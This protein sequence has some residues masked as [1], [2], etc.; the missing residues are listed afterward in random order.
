MAPVMSPGMSWRGHYG[1]VMTVTGTPRAAGASSLPT[2]AQHEIRYGDQVAVV[3]EVGATLRRYDVGD[4]LVVEGFPAD[5]SP[6]GGRGQILAPWP[7]RVADGRYSFDGA[8]LQLPLT[9]VANHNAIHGLVRWVGWAVADAAAD[10][11]SLT[12][13]VWPTPGYPFLLVLTAAYRI[14][15]DGLQVELRARNAGPARA[16]YGAGQHPYLA[17]EGS[18]DTAVLTVPGRTR[19]LTDDRGNPTGT[20]PVAG[21]AHDFTDPR[22]IGD[23]VL[24]TA[25]TDLDRDP[26]GRVR[27]RVA[28]P[29][30]TGV[31]LWAGETVSWLQAFTGD[32]L[33]PERRRRGLAVEPM[34]CPPGALASGRDLT[35]L[36]PGEEHVLTWGLQA[37]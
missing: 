6:D 23:L 17:V 1:R 28:L 19:L 14:D 30:G 29:G 24:D 15:A 36:E 33:A 4:R 10:A 2:G 26:D 22:A 34:S 5:A 13:T 3:T 21:S 37:W 32:T 12:T 9:E 31:D 7:N 25:Y 18:V 27:V 11:V 35:V 8:D 20:E 16:P